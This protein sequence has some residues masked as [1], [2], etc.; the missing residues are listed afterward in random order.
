MAVDPVVPIYLDYGKDISA[1]NHDIL[2]VIV[3]F[4]IKTLVCLLV[5]IPPSLREATKVYDNGKA[6][7]NSRWGIP[8]V[9][10]MAIAVIGLFHSVYVCIDSLDDWHDSDTEE[11]VK[12]VERICKLCPNVK[13]MLLSTPRVKTFFSEVVD[14]SY[15]SSIDLERNHW[16]WSLKAGILKSRLELQLSVVKSPEGKTAEETS[17]EKLAEEYQSWQ[18]L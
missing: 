1:P 5:E 14:A 2:E 6:G 3:R 9:T 8:V 12:W 7:I 13:F 16:I 11:V 4:I 15:S 18:S 10:E 17:I